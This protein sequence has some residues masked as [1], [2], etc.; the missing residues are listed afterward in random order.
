LSH[1]IETEIDQE[2]AERSKK[3]R[4]AERKEQLEAREPEKVKLAEQAKPLFTKQ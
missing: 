4:R 1:R 2:Y 3:V